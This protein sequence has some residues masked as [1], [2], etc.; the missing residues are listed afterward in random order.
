MICVQLFRLGSKRHARLKEAINRI[1]L[2]AV[3]KNNSNSLVDLLI[4]RL[5]GFVIDLKKA[6]S[7][8]CWLFRG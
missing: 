6:K 8:V 4:Q 5:V 7:V 2:I 1:F 3:I